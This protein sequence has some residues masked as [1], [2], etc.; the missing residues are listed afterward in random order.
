MIHELDLGPQLLAGRQVAGL[1]LCAQIVG[2]LPVLACHRP[3][4]LAERCAVG[5]VLL[6]PTAG[7]IYLNRIFGL[8]WFVPNLRVV[9]P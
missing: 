2:D 1:D 8:G 6:V 9:T 3:S 4:S 5:L 7:T